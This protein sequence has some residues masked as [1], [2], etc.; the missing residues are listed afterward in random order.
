VAKLFISSDDVLIKEVEL[1]QERMTIGRRAHNN[2]VLDHRSVSGEHATITLLLDDAVLE[3]VGSTNGT[4]IHGQ[5]VFR[6]KLGDGDLV[7][8]GTFVLRFVAAHSK[9]RPRQNGRIEVLNGAHV[10][11]SMSL[12][13]PLT[14][15]GKPGVAVMAIAFAGGRY[16][17]SRI[18]GENPAWINGKALDAAARILDDGDQINLAGTKMAFH[19]N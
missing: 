14:T 4:V 6:H 12:A 10:G 1:N 17:V 5:K 8:I 15:I 18:D 19:I 2:I 3:D 9:E 11:K 13:K 7:T 16:S